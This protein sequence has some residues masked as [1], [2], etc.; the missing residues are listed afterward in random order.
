LDETVKIEQSTN[1]DNKLSI[2]EAAFN[3]AVKAN[4]DTVN[5]SL[6][7]IMDLFKVKKRFHYI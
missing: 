4:L 5:K 3:A 7:N 2:E 1:D 6:A